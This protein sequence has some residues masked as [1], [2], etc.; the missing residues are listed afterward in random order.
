MTT[1]RHTFPHEVE[2]VENIFVP[3]PDGTRLA[4]KLWRPK[5]VGPVPAILEYLPYRKREGTR[6]RDQKMHAW[7]A[8][9]G[10][11]C[12]RLDIRG[13]GDSEG[14]IEDEYTECEILDGCDAIGWIAGQDWCD[15]QV[16]MYGISWGGFNG[17]Q[18]AA[19]RPPALKTIIT[20]GST[21]DRYAT[22]VHY[23]GGCL[24]K[25]NFDWSATML[26]H[27]DLP[28]DP[29][30]VGPAW[31]DMWQARM[32]ANSPWILHWL[33]HQRRDAYWQHGSVCEDFS[34]ITIPVL[35]VSG[36]AD[37]YSES[38]PRLLAGLSGPRRGLIGPWAHSFPHD[39][40]VEPAI[41]W[42][43]EVRRWCDHWMKG[44]PGGM[45]DDPMYRVWMQESVPPSTCYL[46]R[47]GRW[48]AEAEWPSPRIMHQTLHL[49]P[50]GRLAATA[51]GV[52]EMPV[53]SPLWVGLAAGEVGRYGE[54]AEWPTDQREDDGGSL[55]FATEPL[56]ERT[57]IL[58]AP[59]LHLRFSCDKPMALVAV[60]LNDVWPDGRSTR[61]T[62]GCLNLTHRDSHEHAAA[63][64]P[65]R[66][67][68]AVI[69]LDDIAHAF[70]EGH[71][72]AVSLSTTY[73]PICWPSPE[74]ATLTV[75][76][77]ETWLD[78]PV[79]PTDPADAALRSFAQPEMAAPTP[80]VDLNA[81]SAARRSV[82]RDLLSG[83]MVV[84]FPR[85]TY[86]REMPD[87][88][89]TVTSD[90]FARYRIADGDPLSAS[91]ETGA[92][93]VIQRKDG[94]FGHHST[95]RLT[96]D[97]THFRVETSLRITENGA[98]LFER[99]WDE[100]IPRDHV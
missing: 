74:L 2:I 75:R 10:Y 88:G 94:A 42:L 89:Q 91:C 18:I 81:G 54:D 1:I 22:D 27:N 38:V 6:G 86:A 63:L 32:R 5:G 97:A 26:A 84:D 39:V 55:V 52:D 68:D 66:I 70:P 67:Y 85:W 8:G 44:A 7:L 11:A 3:M 87:I 41:G 100:R 47:P 31:R 4:A 76:T 72:I 48:V 46:E 17:L 50:D 36:W 80:S 29:E 19:R 95:G 45:V 83:E 65:G 25:D 40:T 43:Q 21:D 82:T 12:L 30:I 58:G 56:P 23:V 92:N 69:N 60:R 49:N 14:L 34:A 61:V 35:A 51:E 99:Q 79:R 71:R 98:T 24:S 64:E 15:G 73:W 93:V 33:S 77:G 59:Q 20:V 57:E 9:H 62:L 53:C 13:T 78:L 16:A 90:A 28:P 37:N 96:C